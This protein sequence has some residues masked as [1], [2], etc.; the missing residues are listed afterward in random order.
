MDSPETKPSDPRVQ[1]SRSVL[2]E[3]MTILGAEID[4]LVV[5]GGWVPEL[6]RHD[7]EQLA[8]KACY[9]RL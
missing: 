4:K 5:V 6:P 9:I 3:V 1:A 7:V 2:V 8:D